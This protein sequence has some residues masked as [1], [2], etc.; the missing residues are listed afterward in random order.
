MRRVR[1]SSRNRLMS[2]RPVATSV[3][4][5]PTPHREFTRMPARRPRSTA[6]V[7]WPA[8]WT[9]RSGWRTIADQ[10]QSQ[11]KRAATTG[12][13]D[14]FVWWRS[15]ETF[16]GRCSAISDS[17]AFRTRQEAFP[18]WL[19][20]IR[21]VIQRSWEC[22]ADAGPAVRT[23][24]RAS[25]GSAGQNLAATRV[26]RRRRLAVGMPGRWPGPGDRLSRLWSGTRSSGVPFRRS[27][28]ISWWLRWT[29]R[30]AWIS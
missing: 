18:G 4:R 21:R 23:R 25:G 29:M 30:A 3:P 15:C 14:S 11:I 28:G 5:S 24:I 6:A 22:L 16:L 12:I 26:F 17:S 20:S 9:R 7:G 1:L 8:W 19:E 13:H 10:T 27:L 2:M